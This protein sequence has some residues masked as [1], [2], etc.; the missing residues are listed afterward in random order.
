MTEAP[1]LNPSV[2]FDMLVANGTRLIMGTE[3]RTQRLRW[4]W[5]TAYDLFASLFAIYHPSQFGIR[6]AWAAGVRSRIPAPYR[7]V[8]AAC[9]GF[10]GVPVHWILDQAQPKDAHTVLSRLQKMPPDRVL[11]ELAL[12]ARMADE[13]DSVLTRI[14]TRGEWTEDEQATVAEC[15]RKQTDEPPEEETLV[16][17]L[18]SWTDLEASGAAIVAGVQAYYEN[19]YREEEMRIAESLPESVSHGQALAEKVSVAELLEELT[20]GL[21]IESFA[22]CREIVLIPSFWT[23]PLILYGEYEPGV[24]M[25]VYGARPKNASLVPG[26]VVPDSLSRALSALSDNTRLRIVRLLNQEPR[27]Q[28]E[29]ARALRLRAPTITHHLR[30]LRLAGLVRMSVSSEGEKRYSTRLA[31]IREAVQLLEGFVQGGAR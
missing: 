9:V 10:M 21:D 2:N 25:V 22:A 12:N 16:R 18:R 13:S 26:D 23:T 29:I 8:F 6:P 19:F 15:H 1:P 24:T 17:W 20:Q 11:P 3:R 31:R 5:G 14:S 27:T 28:I 7:E 30:T 4:D